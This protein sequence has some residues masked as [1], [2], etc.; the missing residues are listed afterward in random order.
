MLRTHTRACAW[1]SE[2]KLGGERDMRRQKYG[3]ANLKYVKVER[4]G[5]ERAATRNATKRRGERKREK[6]SVKH[7]EF[8]IP[9]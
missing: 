9:M 1:G 3:S 7:R 6:C 4:E 2:K 8:S 5:S